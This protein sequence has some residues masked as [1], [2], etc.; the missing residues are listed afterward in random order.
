MYDEAVWW[1]GIAVKYD[2]LL[3]GK[4]GG[5]LFCFEGREPIKRHWGNVSLLLINLDG[6]NSIFL[7]PTHTTKK[8]IIRCK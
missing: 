4:F 6:G 1:L 7:Y 5:V 2:D 8:V 3:H